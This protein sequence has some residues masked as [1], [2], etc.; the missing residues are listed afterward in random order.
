MP[1]TIPGDIEPEDF[2]QIRNHLENCLKQIAATGSQVLWVSCRLNESG[3]KNP[4]P[5]FVGWVENKETRDERIRRNDPDPGLYR[6]GDDHYSEIYEECL[7]KPNSVIGIDEAAHQIIGNR[8]RMRW[9]AGAKSLSVKAGAK[10]R[11]SIA[12]K[13]DNQYVGT[14]N[15]GFSNDP[16]NSVDSIMVE[17]AQNSSKSK[18]VQYLKQPQY[19]FGG[20]TGT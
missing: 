14:L 6:F 11:M 7:N 15:A 16:A 3:E 2:I 4:S 8:D 17:W 9:L 1:K 19:D 12:I 5:Y 20:P 13:V 10:Y 18:L